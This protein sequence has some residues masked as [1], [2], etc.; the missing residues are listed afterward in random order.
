MTFNAHFP[1]TDPIIAAADVALSLRDILM[2]EHQRFSFL[3]GLAVGNAYVGILGYHRFRSVAC[4]VCA[5]CR[6]LGPGST[7]SPSHPTASKCS[8][9]QRGT[10]AFVGGGGGNIYSSNGRRIA[11]FMLK[12]VGDWGAAHTTS[13]TFKG[14]GVAILCQSHLANPLCARLQWHLV[15]SGQVVGGV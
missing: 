9:M 14:L 7:K 6:G 5:L 8:K 13:V 3:M 4:M 10:V 1:C 15:A 2:R 12:G 11:L